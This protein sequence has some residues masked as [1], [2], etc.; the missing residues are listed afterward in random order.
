MDE[1]LIV[2]AVVREKTFIGKVNFPVNIPEALAE[3]FRIPD[4]I[5]AHAPALGLGAREVK[6][7]LGI[8]KGRWAMTVQLDLPDLG[9]KLGMT[10]PEMDAIVCDLVKKGY[11]QVGTRLNLYRFWIVLLRL[12]GLR[13]DVK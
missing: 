12:K 3:Y 5:L 7:L 9:P 11:A 13:F 10:F 2:D 8:T 6:F 4:D 1:I